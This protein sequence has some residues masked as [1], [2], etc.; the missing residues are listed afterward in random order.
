MNDYHARPTE[1]TC[2]YT[3]RKVMETQ[4]KKRLTWGGGELGN[5]KRENHVATRVGD[6]SS[7]FLLSVQE[8]A[9][10]P[11]AE[12]HI[13]KRKGGKRKVRVVGGLGYT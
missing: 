2:K 5:Q 8:Q 7:R 3:I 1:I 10:S 6:S 11:N 4:Q 12:I 9:A 13:L